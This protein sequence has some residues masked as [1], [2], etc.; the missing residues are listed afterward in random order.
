MN[1]EKLYEKIISK[2]QRENRNKDSSKYE[3]HHIIPRSLGGDN[4]KDNLVYLTFREHYIS[5]YLLTKIHKSSQELLYAF[6]GMNNQIIGDN[7]N[8]NYRINSKFFESCRKKIVVTMKGNTHCI[9]NKHTNKT[10]E[11]MSEQATGTHHYGFK[12]YYIT[13]LGKYPS[14]AEA[15]EYGYPKTLPKWC[16]ENDKIIGKYSVSQSPML[17]RDDIGKTFKEIGYSFEKAKRVIPK[18]KTT[19]PKYVQKSGKEHPNQG[20]KATK[21][22]IEQMSVNSSGENNNWFKGYFITP[23]G[24]FTSALDCKNKTGHGMGKWCKD[25]ERL[26]TKLLVTTKPDIFNENDIGKSFK[27]LGYS[28]KKDN[29]DIILKKDNV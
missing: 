27:E 14:V 17:S 9:G 29:Y 18:T 2:A 11:L 15:V 24:K 5:H 1:Y 25:N 4:N 6:W 10:K 19:K 23:Y 22:Q 3:L 21:K 12:G 28:F 26:V 13:P 8:R 16:K 20:R 7:T